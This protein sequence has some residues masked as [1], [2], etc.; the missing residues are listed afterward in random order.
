M[1]K[2]QRS[3]ILSFYFGTV[4]LKSARI[5]YGRKEY[6]KEKKGVVKLYRKMTR[7]SAVS[8]FYFIAL[9][10]SHLLGIYGGDFYDY[11]KSR[12]LE[13]IGLG[14]MDIGIFRRP[15][16]DKADRNKNTRQRTIR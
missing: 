9:V 3:V 13:E 10:E 12:G 7:S 8:R 15:R 1:I 11:L 5:P 14:N 2:L 4:G 6:V 16:I